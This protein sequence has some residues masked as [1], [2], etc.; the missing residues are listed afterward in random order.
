MKSTC[1]CGKFH[2]LCIHS[3]SR[4][5]LIAVEPSLSVIHSLLP[6]IHLVTGLCATRERFGLGLWVILQAEYCLSLSA[7]LIFHL[8]ISPIVRGGT[9]TFT[10]FQDTTGL[11]APVLEHRN[12]KN[13]IDMESDANLNQKMGWKFSSQACH[14]IG[15]YTV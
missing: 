4:G 3:V 9:H 15:A 1:N 10:D 13:A 5:T 2:Q 6:D 12:P 7:M 11:A 14:E 8:L